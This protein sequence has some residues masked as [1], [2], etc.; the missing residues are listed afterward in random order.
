[1]RQHHDH[2]QMQHLR[3]PWAVLRSASAISSGRWGSMPSGRP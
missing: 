1:V 2:D 3:S